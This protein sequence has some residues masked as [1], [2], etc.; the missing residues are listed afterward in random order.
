MVWAHA[1]A[2]ADAKVNGQ[3]V[4]KQR[5]TSAYKKRLETTKGLKYIVTNVP[6]GRLNTLLLYKEISS[7]LS[8]RLAA[9]PA[10]SAPSRSTTS[11]ASSGADR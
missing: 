7:L 3:V 8:S 11:V 10:A 9:T 5:A 1:A 4:Y 6:G 2:A